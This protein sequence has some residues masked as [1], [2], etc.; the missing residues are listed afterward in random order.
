[1]N[2]DFE[3]NNSSISFREDDF[4]IVAREPGAKIHDEKFQSR[5]TTFFKDAMRRFVKNKAS[6][7]GGVIIG[8]LLFASIFSFASPYNIDEPMGSIARL[9][10]KIRN[11]GDG[12]WDGTQ[13]FTDI[14]YDAEN[15]VPYGYLEKN[16]VKG[17]LQIGDAIYYDD[18]PNEFAKGGYYRLVA[19]GFTTDA[20]GKFDTY[21]FASYRKFSNLKKSDALVISFSIGDTADVGG[22][23]LAPLSLSLEYEDEMGDIAYLPLLENVTTAQEYS[24]SV[25]D[26]MNDAGLTSL[27]KAR[28]YFSFPTYSDARG[29]VLIDHVNL[30]VADTSTDT[31]KKIAEDISFDDA[32]WVAKVTNTETYPEQYWQS[33]GFRKI[34]H[35]VGYKC[36]FV[37]DQYEAVL[38]LRYDMHIGRSFIEEYIQKG[39]CEMSNFNDVSTF[40]LTHPE[41]DECPVRSLSALLPVGADGVYQYQGEVLYYRWLGYNSMPMFILGTDN[42][43]R[44]LLT[45]SLSCLKNSLLLALVT[46]AICIVIGLIW[47][48]IS[49]YFGGWVDL[50]ME[51]ITDILSGVPWIVVMTL[52]ML[53]LGRNIVTFGIAI[54]LTGWIGTASR[55]RSQFYRFKGREYVLASRTLG[56]S[57]MRLIFRHILPNGL[58]TIV[59]SSVLMIPSTIFSEATLSY[60]GLGLQGTQSFG[61]LL[62]E[63]QANLSSRPALIIFPSIIISLLMIS[64]NL[65]GNGLRDALNPTLKGGEQ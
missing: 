64:F 12:W 27:I 20:G 8:I 28:P 18:D 57:D 34:Y 16:I 41:S 19:D 1:M 53:L 36:S 37:Y 5:P 26:K 62:A 46:S 35:A 6:V 54:V 3:K 51:R 13:K 45:L 58:G 60:L 50:I 59:T 48:S 47:G 55:T 42:S 11:G 2:N 17:T 43:G 40:R 15:E 30:A 7:V 31:V 9:V 61:V 33:N 10:P 25:A 38:G 49:G 44:D 14:I 22:N 4:K 24:I 56:A 39:W 65:F 52:V 21:Y 32:N 23:R 29:Y 63:N